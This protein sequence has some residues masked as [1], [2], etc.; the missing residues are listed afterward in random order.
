[1]GLDAYS[2]IRPISQQ[3]RDLAAVLDRTGV[4]LGLAGWLR[5]LLYREPRIDDWD[6]MA[7]RIQALIERAE[8]CR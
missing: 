6:R 8:T 7:T 5:R 4:V 1:M 2:T 3:E